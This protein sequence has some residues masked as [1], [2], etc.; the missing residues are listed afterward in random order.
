MYFF[1]QI[2]TELAAYLEIYPR[3]STQGL[4]YDYASIMHYHAYVFSS[5]SHPSLIIVPVNIS[6][7]SMVLGSSPVPTEYDYLHINFKYCGGKNHCILLHAWASACM[8]VCVFLT[9]VLTASIQTH[10]YGTI[11]HVIRTW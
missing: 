9:I 7:Q 8:H 4:P 2:N 5:P 6:I 1:F 10:G 3:S 11:Q